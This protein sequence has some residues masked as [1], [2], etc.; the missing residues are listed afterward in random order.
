MIPNVPGIFE[1][2][3]AISEPLSLCEGCFLQMNQSAR[4]QKDHPMAECAAVFPASALQ[5]DR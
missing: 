1:L 3:P 5:G 2:A 4:L